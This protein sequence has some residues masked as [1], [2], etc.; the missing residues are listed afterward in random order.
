MKAIITKNHISGTINIAARKG[1]AFTVLPMGSDRE[2]ILI[3]ASCLYTSSGSK[4][5]WEDWVDALDAL[6]L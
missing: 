1:G 2:E 4:D 3:E 5:K 6:D